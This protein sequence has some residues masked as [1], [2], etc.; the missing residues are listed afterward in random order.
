MVEKAFAIFSLQ[1]SI[2]GGF[3]QEELFFSKRNTAYKID[4]L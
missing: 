3:I 4:W 1:D 2:K